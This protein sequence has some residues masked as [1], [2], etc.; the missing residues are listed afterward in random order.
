M[1]VLIGFSGLVVATSVG[2]ASGD[3][4][5]P[6]VPVEVEVIYK[7]APIEDASVAFSPAGD[8]LAAY[9]RTGPGGKALLST[10]GDSD[11]VLPGS[12]QVG[13]S[14]RSFVGGTQIPDDY[15][16]PLPHPGY[17]EPKE[18]NEL[19][20]KYASPASSGLEATVTEGAG[21]N[22]FRFELTD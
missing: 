9:G 5:P 17:V 12:Y 1:M 18:V 2:C 20:E 19:P 4:H 11:G 13:L 21:V 14:K 16:G 3:G 7:G 10:F 8:G 22:T 15:D 6:R